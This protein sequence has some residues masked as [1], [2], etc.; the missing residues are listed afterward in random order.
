[1]PPN[2]MKRLV[3]RNNPR[4]PVCVQS[5]AGDDSALSPQILEA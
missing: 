1:V 3:L 2:G 4:F 5:Q